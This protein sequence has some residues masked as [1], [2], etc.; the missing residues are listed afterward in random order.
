MLV[1]IRPRDFSFMNEQNLGI[2]FGMLNEL[3]IHANMIQTSALNLSICIDENLA[4]LNQ[5]IDSLEQSFLIKY[6]IGLQLFTIRH[7]TEGIERQFIQGRKI[8]I[9]QRSRST[10]QLVLGHDDASK[11]FSEIELGTTGIHN[12][13]G[14][15]LLPLGKEQQHSN[16]IDCWLLTVDYWPFAKKDLSREPF[17]KNSLNYISGKTANPRLILN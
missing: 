12:D 11:W 13:T 5:L 7:Y 10:L 3:N 2:L 1:T 4:K 9:E 8:F 6:N 15:T 14:T 17:G 16:P